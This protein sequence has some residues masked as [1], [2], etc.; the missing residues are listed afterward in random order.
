MAH[1]HK[2]P[3]DGSGPVVVP[4]ITPT[5][6]G[7]KDCVAAAPALV[8]DIADHPANYYVDI[9]TFKFPAGAV[10]GQLGK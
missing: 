10:R 1:I 9:H 8:K 3:P 6:Y 4:L 2:G 5:V 7:S